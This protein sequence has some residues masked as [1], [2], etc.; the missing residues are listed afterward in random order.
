[1]EISVNGKVIKPRRNDENFDLR[2]TPE[3]CGANNFWFENR[4]IHFVVNGQPDCVVNVKE[5][6]MVFVSMRLAMTKDEFFS[7]NRDTKYIDRI[8]AF[9]KISTDKLKIVRV[10]EVEIAPAP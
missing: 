4:T 6:D 10:Y 2:T 5:V 8:C 7:N 9:L 1:L 3:A